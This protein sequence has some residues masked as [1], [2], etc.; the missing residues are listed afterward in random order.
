MTIMN[1][2]ENQNNDFTLEI[3][4]DWKDCYLNMDKT[5]KDLDLEI[6]PSMVIVEKNEG[7]PLCVCCVIALY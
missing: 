4:V 1:L 3:C 6:Y 7:A 5:L 2:I